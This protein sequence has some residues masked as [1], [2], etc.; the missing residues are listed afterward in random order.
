MTNCF[1]CVRL[2]AYVT[3]DNVNVLRLRTTVRICDIWISQCE[4]FVWYVWTIH[5]CN[6]WSLYEVEVT[7]S[8]AITVTDLFLS[9]HVL[10]Y[11]T[12]GPTYK[13]NGLAPTSI[14]VEQT[15]M[16]NV[17][18]VFNVYYYQKKT[19]KKKTTSYCSCLSSV[20][21]ALLDDMY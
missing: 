21:L 15:F 7:I 14:F 8:G 9:M 12:H 18:R 3:H 10:F 17:I 5:I 1:V 20:Y 19:K 2:Y 13:T 16:F 6:T 4:A 11:L